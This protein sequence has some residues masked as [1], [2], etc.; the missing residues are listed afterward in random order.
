M[1][2]LEGKNTLITGGGTG[3]GRGITEVFLREGA[4]VTIAARREDV[5][6]ETVDLAAQWLGVGETG[7]WSGRRPRRPS[8]ATGKS[9]QYGIRIHL[10]V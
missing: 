1:G 7:P 8:R 6:Q 4:N 9:N 10:C 5:L 2:R 3:I